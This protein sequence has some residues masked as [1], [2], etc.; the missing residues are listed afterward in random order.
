MLQFVAGRSYFQAPFRL[1]IVVSAWDRIIPSNRRPSDWI[2]AELPL[3][4]QFF[5]SNDDLFEVTFFGISAQGVRYALPHFWAGNFKNSQ[6]FAKRVCE[7]GDPISAW[8]WAK[9]DPTS[10]TTLDLLRNGSDATELQK[11]DLAKDLNILIAAPDIY[12]ETR[13]RTSRC[14]QKRRAC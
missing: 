4:K 1:A 5:E 14:D 8:I 13:S 7:Q 9:L 3:L 12:D 2:A 11:K 10:Q 6:S